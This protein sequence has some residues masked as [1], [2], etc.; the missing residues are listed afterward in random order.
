MFIFFSA[1]SC[2]EENIPSS[3][4]PSVVL[5]AVQPEYNSTDIEWEMEGGFYEAEIE[6]NDS[7]ELTLQINEAGKLIM[8]KQDIPRIL[9]PTPILASIESQYKEFSFEDIEELKKDSVT[10][11]QFELRSNGSVFNLVFN[12]EGK[13][14]KSIAYWN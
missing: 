7:T 12:N 4:V 14:D 11:Y 8:Q 2:N 13:I 1:A 5:N 3:E 9:I 10:Y 6:V